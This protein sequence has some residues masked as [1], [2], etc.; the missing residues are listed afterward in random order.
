MDFV[1]VFGCLHPIPHTKKLR[2]LTLIWRSL[3]EA[4]QSE[5]GVSSVVGPPFIDPRKAQMVIFLIFFSKNN[6]DELMV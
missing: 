2:I 6:M 3:E 1:G 4:E 5:L